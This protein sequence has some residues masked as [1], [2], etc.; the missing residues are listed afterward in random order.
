M[1]RQLSSNVSAVSRALDKLKES[2][3]SKK[4][5]NDKSVAHFV[6]LCGA[7]KPN[8][9]PPEISERRAAIQE[10]GRRH[11]PDTRFILAENVFEYLV[12]SHGEYRNNILDLESEFSF[13]SDHIII[14]LESNSTFSELGAFSYPMELREKLIIINDKQFRDKTSFVNMGPIKAIEERWDG[15]NPILWYNMRGDGVSHRDAIGDTF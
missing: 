11:L 8:T 5:Y 1:E 14:I 12:K 4:V 15:A 2:I 13:I 9:E 7:N 6:F 10:F 3:E